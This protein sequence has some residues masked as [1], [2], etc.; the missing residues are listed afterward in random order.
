MLL[1]RNHGE[2]AFHPTDRPWPVGM[3]T[4]QVLGYNPLLTDYLADEAMNLDYSWS[5]SSDHYVVTMVKG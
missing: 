5:W 2:A 3:V 4:T 1:C